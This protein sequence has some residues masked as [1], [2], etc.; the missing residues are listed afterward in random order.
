[1]ASDINYLVNFDDLYKPLHLK[2]T[3]YED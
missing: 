2:P 3:A 1:M